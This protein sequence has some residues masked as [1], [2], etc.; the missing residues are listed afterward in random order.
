MSELMPMIK[1]FGPFLVIIIFFSWWFVNS[2]KAK[3]NVQKIIA[4][5]PTYQ[6]IDVRTPAE[7]NSESVKGSI[8][9]PLAELQ[10]RMG[11]IKKD[12]PVII[13]CQ[14]GG[15]S[16]SGTGILKDNGF[17]NVVDG[18]GIGN[19]KSALNQN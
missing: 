11:E 9:I 18:G 15:R 6:L 1:K 3:S 19:I 4:E 13:F 2:S 10:V 7:F 17:D 8:N 14:S 12:I 16:R 5:N